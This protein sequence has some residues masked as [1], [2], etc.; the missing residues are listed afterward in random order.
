MNT[1]DAA[2]PKLHPHVGGPHSLTLPPSLLTSQGSL[3]GDISL[4]GT[5]PTSAALTWG[6]GPLTTGGNGS[7]TWSFSKNN[8]SA[9]RDPQ[10]GQ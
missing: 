5:G 4:E 8:P 3:R 2:L 10:A 9:T 6:T 1:G 7:L